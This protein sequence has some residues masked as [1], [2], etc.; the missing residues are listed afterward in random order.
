MQLILN[1]I[2]CS[3]ISR[4]IRFIFLKATSPCFPFLLHLYD[5]LLSLE[6]NFFTLTSDYQHH[7][8]IPFNLHRT[9]H[10][11]PNHYL[12]KNVPASSIH[13]IHINGQHFSKHFVY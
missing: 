7:P 1:V 4:Q 8:A 6:G 9:L 10:S 2:I 12:Y 3:V 13:V 11:S 5:H